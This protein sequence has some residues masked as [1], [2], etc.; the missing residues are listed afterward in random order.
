M[1]G[2]ARDTTLA[3]T[4]GATSIYLLF[5]G[6][7]YSFLASHFISTGFSGLAL[8]SFMKVRGTDQRG[9]WLLSVI[10]LLYTSPSPRDATLSRMPSSA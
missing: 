5:M 9:L 7:W 8:A 6:E 2:L 1:F 4:T 3:L 10:C